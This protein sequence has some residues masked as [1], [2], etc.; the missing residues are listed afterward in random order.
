MLREDDIDKSDAPKGYRAT[1]PIS[2]Y[3]DLCDGCDLSGLPECALNKK[4]YSCLADERADGMIVI[5]IEEEK[6]MRD[7]LA[8][9]EKERRQRLGKLVPPPSEVEPF[10]VYQEGSFLAELEALINKHS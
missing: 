1:L 2:P 6:A 7:E 9:K 5:F 8:R 10:S 4:S 3:P